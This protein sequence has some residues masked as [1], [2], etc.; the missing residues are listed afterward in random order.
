MCYKRVG[1]SFY[2]QLAVIGVLTYLVHEAAHWGVGAA[3]G[4][5]VKFGLNAVTSSVPMTEMDHILFSLSGPAVTIVGAVLAFFWVKR[6][7]SLAAYGVLYFA[8]FMRLVAAGISVFNLNDEARASQLL[9]IG[10]WTLPAL[11]V[12]GLGTLTIIA[13]RRLRLS[14]KVNGLAY[15]VSSVVISVFVGLDMVLRA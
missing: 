6:G 8:F 9:G 2:L 10:P 5:P 4:Y 3:L 13:S 1:A 12:V 7:N 15:L 14:W 11:V